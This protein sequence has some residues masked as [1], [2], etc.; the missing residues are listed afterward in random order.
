MRPRLIVLIFV[1]FA[2]PHTI[3]GDDA[4]VPNPVH[5]RAKA[6]LAQLDGEIQI[7]FPWPSG[8]KVEIVRDRY[9]IPHIFGEEDLDVFCAQ[10]FVA[11]QDR[12]FQIDWW[13]RVANGE[14]AEVLGK[15]ALEADRFA[16]LIRYRGDMNAEWASYGPDAKAIATAFTHGINAYVEHIGAKLPIEFQIAGYEPKRWRAED[17]LGRMSGIVMSRNFQQEIA[18]AQLIAEVGVEKARWLAPTDPSRAFAPAAGLDLGGI[19][20]RIS[21]GYRAATKGF[22]FTPEKTQSNNWVVAS[23]KSASG[24]PLLAS[25]PHRTIAVP[26]LRS[27]VHLKSKTMNVI[28]AGEPAL[29]GIALGHNE[30]I[31]WGFTIIG[32]DQE[33]LYVEETHPDDPTQYKTPAGWEK[34]RIV[35]ETIRVKGEAEPVPVE[36]RYTRNGPV[37]FQDAKRNRAFALRW[38]GSEPG[39]AAY[40]AGLAVG[41]ARNQE[42]FLKAISRWKIPALNFVYADRQHTIGWI[43]AGATPIRKNHD[44]LL[45]VPGGAGTF[46]W[47]GFLSVNEWPQSFNPADGILATANH[48]IVPPGYRHEIGYEFS[49]PYRFLRIKERLQAA[50][51]FDLDDFKS[52]QHDEVSIPGQ[53]LARLVKHVTFVDETRR[54]A[55]R[56]YMDLLARWDGSL[57]KDSQAGPLFAV[58][59]QELQAD[60]YKPHV[61][62]E[63]L[64]NARDLSGLPVMLQALEKPDRNWF[65]PNPEARRDDLLRATFVRAVERTKK[66]LASDDP[67]TWSWG[68]LHTVTFKHPLSSLGKD[69]ADAFNRGPLPRGGDANTPNNTKHDD[70]FRQIHGASYRHLLD[71]ADWDRGLAI[72]APGQSGQPGSPFYD[73]LLARWAAAEY[74]PLHYSAE[75]IAKAAQHRLILRAAR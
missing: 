11:A 40:L 73:N 16:R 54:T 22:G 71:L 45:P 59:L 29:P 32:T 63:L 70:L 17:I 48:N 50:K 49:A 27:M 18:R 55:M 38:S 52:I 24:A 66:L 58:W 2:S 19:D 6:V 44:G 74:I 25:D 20:A 12:L 57:A 35:H 65:G 43:A 37:L 47:Q 41:R 62:K 68:K 56:P 21:A 36:L 67:Q 4:S 9:G 13:R 10:G 1:C 30:Q 14:T 5:D 39:G 15:Q 53:T 3:Y 51:R 42:E 34:M 7:A 26:S 23:S 61:S 31:A 46:D 75:A 28:G 8:G 69:Y 60:F 72:N 64:P 33:D